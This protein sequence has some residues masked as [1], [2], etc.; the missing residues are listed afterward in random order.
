MKRRTWKQISA[1]LAI[2][3]CVTCNG[4][5]YPVCADSKKG[6]TQSAK[7]I[8]MEDLQMEEQLEAE[9]VWEYPEIW[10]E[11]PQEKPVEETLEAPVEEEIELFT[12]G[13]DSF[14]D[15]EEEDSLFGSGE[16]NFFAQEGTEPVGEDNWNGDQVTLDIKEG[17]K[18]SLLR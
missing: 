11:L 12:A 3:V 1:M 17:G 5:T 8:E 10:T 4:M 2:S 6:L 16:E 7:E 13:E 9:E 14:A 15:G 18:I